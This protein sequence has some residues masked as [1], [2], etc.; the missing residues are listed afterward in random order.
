MADKFIPYGRQEIDDGDVQAVAEALRSDWLTTGPTVERFENAFADFA[1]SAHAVAAANGTAAL[2]LTMLAA[3]VGPGDEVIVPPLTFAATANCAR[4]VGAT[5]VFADIRP[6]TL[7]IDVD[8]VAARITPRTKAIIAV[9]YAGLPC[10]LDELMTLAERHDLLVV[11]DA[12]H[13]L[14]AD[15]RGRRIGSIAHM[16]TFSLHPVKHITTGEGGV[17]TTN[18]AKLAERLRRLR[19][20]GISSDHRQR[21]H[22]GTWR[23]DV[24]ELGFN[25]RLTDIQCA[26]G[27]SQLKKAPARLER[28]RALAAAYGKAFAKHEGLRVPVEPGDR[29]H[30]WHLYVARLAGENVAARRQRMF[31]TLRAAQIGANVHYLPVYLFS[32]YR[33]LG[34]E[35]G[36]CPVAEREYD[37]LLSLPM[38]AGLSDEDQQ[39]VIRTVIAAESG[40]DS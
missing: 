39:R 28:R 2:H 30:A 5:V 26:L 14:G 24:V 3:G 10:D 6:D 8:Q 16:T 31:N 7:T 32:Y 20:H 35:P 11:E 21:Q 19:N 33:S 38:W 40:H 22:E 29:N 15:Y 36:L 25:Y 18:D 23:Y 37:G 13:A 1:G 4:Y 17:V 34:Y 9:D 27:L 12:A